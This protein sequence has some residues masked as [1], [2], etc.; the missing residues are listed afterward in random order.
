MLSCVS[1]VFS[2]EYLKFALQND[3]TILRYI[4]CL[5]Q[6]ITLVFSLTCR[7]KKLCNL[8]YLEVKLIWGA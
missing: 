2:E 3:P 7:V 6:S 5:P 1:G 8:F 4:F